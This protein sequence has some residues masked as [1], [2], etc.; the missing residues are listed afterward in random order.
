MKYMGIIVISQ[1]MKNRKTSVAVNTA[2]MAPS[3]SRT[4]LMN[5]LR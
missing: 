1:A 3:T 5:A 4:R 2:S